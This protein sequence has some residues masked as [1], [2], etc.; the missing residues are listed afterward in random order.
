MVVLAAVLGYYAIS[1][2][3]VWTTG[4]SN[5]VRPVDAIVVMG[6]AQ[7]DGTPSPQLAARLDHVVADLA[8][9]RGAR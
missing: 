1:L 2:F 8:R 6:A 4:R 7:Y 5:E 9:Q 3:Q